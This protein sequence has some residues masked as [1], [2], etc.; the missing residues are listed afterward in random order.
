MFGEIKKKYGGVD[1]CINNAGLGVDA[2]LTGGETAKW[3]EMLDVSRLIIS[4]PLFK[5]IL[6]VYCF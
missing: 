5:Q 1:V 2:S 3:K 4:F 6:G